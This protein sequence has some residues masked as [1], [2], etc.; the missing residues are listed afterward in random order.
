MDGWMELMF[1]V[2]SY[3]EIALLFAKF[4]GACVLIC[5]HVRFIL[6]ELYYFELQTGMV[7]S[8]YLK[9]QFPVFK[10]IPAS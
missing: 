3:G 5:R 7:F 8:E 4:I 9:H 6:S 2:F 1:A 10:L